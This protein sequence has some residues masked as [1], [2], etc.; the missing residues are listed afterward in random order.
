VQ[1]AVT[2]LEQLATELAGSRKRQQVTLPR[3][4]LGEAYLRAGRIADARVQADLVLRMARERGERLVEG[5]ALVLAG[6]VAGHPETFRFDEGVAAFAEAAAIA[7]E[8]G[9][10]LLTAHA[11]L[12]L[13]RLLDRA[14]HQDAGRALAR[15]REMFAALGLPV[16]ELNLLPRG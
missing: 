15:A 4:W 16:G 9:L 13:A 11:Q 8:G 7:E 1:Q 2:E 12:G 10:R 6:E 5:W 3:L 14:G